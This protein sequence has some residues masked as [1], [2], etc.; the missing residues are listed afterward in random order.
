MRNSDVGIEAD[1]GEIGFH[2]RLLQLIGDA[3]SI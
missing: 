2:K 1:S 3:A